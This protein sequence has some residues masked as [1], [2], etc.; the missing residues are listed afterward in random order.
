MTLPTPNRTTRQ[1]IPQNIR[2]GDVV[3]A[4][5]GG[6]KMT[7]EKIDTN[8]DGYVDVIYFHEDHPGMQGLQRAKIH[9]DALR[10]SEHTAGDPADPHRVAGDPEYPYGR[11]AHG[12][13]NLNPRDPNRTVAGETM[14]E[15][16]LAEQRRTGND[17]KAPYGRDANGNALPNPRP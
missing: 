4:S 14:N 11:D 5:S 17:P 1:S 3:T 16:Q 6:P 15:Q 7:V 8:N 12:N 2:V 10:L 13:P 9:R